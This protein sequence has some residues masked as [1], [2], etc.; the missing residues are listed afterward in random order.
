MATLKDEAKAYI[1]KQTKNVAE[2]SEVSIDVEMKDG[3]GID[4]EGNT[5]KYKYIEI[6][7]EEYRVPKA[8][9]GQIKDLL[10]DNANLKRF[11]VKKAG[12]GLKTRYTTI[13]LS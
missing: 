5:F 12:E 8:V 11:K 9:L 7:N 3:E 13:P 6:N 4:N 2:L 1:P 10:E